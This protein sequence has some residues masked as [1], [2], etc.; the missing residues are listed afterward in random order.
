[1]DTVYLIIALILVIPFSYLLAKA[2]ARKVENDVRDAE[3]RHA[4]R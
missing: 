2:S 4:N 1:M 3:A